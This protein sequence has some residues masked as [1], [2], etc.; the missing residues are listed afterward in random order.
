MQKTLKEIAALIAGEVVGD[1]NIIIKGVCS[2]KEARDGDI[3]F[4]AN[5]KYLPF[6]EITK[7]SAII[8]SREIKTASKPIIRTDNPSIAFAKIV[9]LFSPCEVRHPIG[10]HASA[11]LG[12]D[13]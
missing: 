8:T 7:A 3:T 13:V 11:I 6:I 9:S 4:L 2:I 10:I 12:K 1:S 5:P